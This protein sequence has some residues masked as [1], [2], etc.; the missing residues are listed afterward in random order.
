[1][2]GYRQHY[3]SHPSSPASPLRPSL[4]SDRNSLVFSCIVNRLLQHTPLARP[5][6]RGLSNLLHICNATVHPI[7]YA[8]YNPPYTHLEFRALMMAPNKQTSNNTKTRGE[9]ITPGSHVTCSSV[10]L[11]KGI[12]SGSYAC[13]V[14]DVAVN[15]M[16]CDAIGM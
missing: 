9:Q 5:N 2:Q 13:V 8:R 10:E 16:N 3:T 15:T 12:V 7:T 6:T 11:Y 1:M 4:N 14:W